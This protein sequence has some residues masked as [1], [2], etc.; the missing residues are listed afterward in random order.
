MDIFRLKVSIFSVATNYVS[1]SF[2]NGSL[3]LQNI[4]YLGFSNHYCKMPSANTY[5]YKVFL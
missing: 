5:Y 3:L 2:S 4:P 1:L